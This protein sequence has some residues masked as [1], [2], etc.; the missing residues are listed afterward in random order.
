MD[1]LA[2]PQYHQDLQQR[3]EE[4]SLLQPNSAEYNNNQIA[5]QELQLYLQP[6]EGQ[7]EMM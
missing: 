4:L 7:W 3:Q 6:H 5:I 2:M 1:Y